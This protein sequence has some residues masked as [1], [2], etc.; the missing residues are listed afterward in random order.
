MWARTHGGRHAD[1][2]AGNGPVVLC[3]NK[4]RRSRR[5]SNA[6]DGSSQRRC[7]CATRNRS[8][9]SATPRCQPASSAPTSLFLMS[10][11]SSSTGPNRRL[12]ESPA[13]LR[14]RPS[15]HRFRSRC[16]AI[17]SY[18]VGRPRSPQQ[19]AGT[20][21][22]RC[23]S[24]SASSLES[25]RGARARG[26]GCEPATI[27]FFGKAD[28][29]HRARLTSCQRTAQPLRRGRAR[30]PRPSPARALD[31]LQ[32]EALVCHHGVYVPQGVLGVGGDART[33]SP[34]VVNSG[35][36]PTAIAP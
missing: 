28:L 18:V 2:P 4:C 3:A 36:R 13:S 10:A 21:A 6:V 5:G 33:R 27:R 20:R 23:P 22:R 24:T 34:R 11:N 25:R 26:A 17:A 1:Q 7:G 15:T 32:P 35:A 9:S 29:E 8:S 19:T 31:R 30:R 16:I 14:A 12:C